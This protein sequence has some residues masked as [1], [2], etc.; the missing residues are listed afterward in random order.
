MILFDRA[1]ALPVLAAM[2]GVERKRTD[3]PGGHRG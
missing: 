3:P 2:A 1:N